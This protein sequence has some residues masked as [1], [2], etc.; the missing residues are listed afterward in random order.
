MFPWESS[1]PD[2]SVQAQ[3]LEPA[4]LHLPLMLLYNVD[5]RFHV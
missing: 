5:L 2:I 1:A 3:D 4:Y